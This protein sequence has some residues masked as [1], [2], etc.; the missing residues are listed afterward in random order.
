MRVCITDFLSNT[1][2]CVKALSLTQ[3]LL[4]GETLNPESAVCQASISNLL[5]CFRILPRLGIIGVVQS[6]VSMY[7]NKHG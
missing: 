3:V 5:E 7:M 1:K 2:V 6:N 4:S